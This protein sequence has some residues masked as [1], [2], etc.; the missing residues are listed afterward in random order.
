[1][2]TLKQCQLLPHN[3]VMMA[4]LCWRS[5]SP[6]LL[7][8]FKFEMQEEEVEREMYPPPEKIICC[9]VKDL[10]KMPTSYYVHCTSS[11]KK[12]GGDL[13]H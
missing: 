12:I 1:M 11:V 13:R 2:G 9:R 7:R 6:S 10:Q 5:V 3:S 8:D 4:K